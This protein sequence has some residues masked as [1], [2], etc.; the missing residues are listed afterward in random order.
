M[1]RKEILARAITLGLLLAMPFSNAW[2]ATATQSKSTSSKYSNDLKLSF[3][4]KW[5]NKH[6]TGL[7]TY[8]NSNAKADVTIEFVG[9]KISISGKNSIVPSQKYNKTKTIISGVYSYAASKKGDSYRA[10][11]Y[12]GGNNTSD[13]SIDV[14]GYGIAVGVYVNG[15]SNK[16]GSKVIITGDNFTVASHSNDYYAYG[17]YVGNNTTDLN[18]KATSTLIINADNTIINASSDVKIDETD[19]D[20]HGIG[21]TAFSQGVVEINGNL[22]VN[23]DTVLSTRGNAVTKINAANDS[24]KTIKLNGN[25]DFNYSNTTKVDADVTINLANEESYLNGNIVPTGYPM[26]DGYDEINSMKL[27]ISNSAQWT[28]DSASRVNILTLDG[29]IINLL[30][31]SENI[32]IVAVDALKGAG[33]TVNFAVDA[34]GDT[35]AVGTFDVE[36]SDSSA[37]VTANYNGITADNVGTKEKFAKL[38]HNSLKIGGVAEFTAVVKEGLLTPSMTGITSNDKNGNTLEIKDIQQGTS[39]TTMDAMRDIASTA[40]IAWRQED[41]TLSQRLGEL[42][43]SEGDQGVWVRM[44]RGE[45]EYSG[46][47]KNQYNYFQMGYDKAYGDWH[48]GAAISHNDG[49]TAYANGKGDNRSTSLSLYGTWLGERGHYADIVL[50]QGRLNNEFEI[51]TEAGDT[52]GDYGAWGT[53]LSG[54]YGVKVDMSDG[55]YVTPQA[56]LT[57]MRI[58]GE[59][60]TT[61]NN[62]RV[63]QDTLYSMVGRIGFELGKKITNKGSVYAKASLLH[64]FAGDADTYL[65][66]GDLHNSYSQDIGNTLYEAGLGFNYKTS[67]DSYIYADV[68]KTVGDDIKTPWQWN[69][70]MRWSF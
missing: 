46:A 19:G 18:G 9:E 57:F 42:R 13:I 7:Q 24:D 54:E 30:N 29:G 44:S 2:A 25:I 59:D 10:I 27:G 32:Q 62:I 36:N 65:R 49:K 23:A 50:K 41:S 60:Y 64:E 45:F 12:L 33:G 67:A 48:Y 15:T 22:E 16:Q 40:I 66:L 5:E 3:D 35:L 11:T 1:K 53:S 38:V 69:A 39:T 6:C 58:G 47:Y 63:S 14:D 56:Q 4:N 68:V 17:L 52:R 8:V 26:P 28:T 61:S 31:K 37:K 55:W 51:H 21:I 20:F 43:N 34:S 70:G